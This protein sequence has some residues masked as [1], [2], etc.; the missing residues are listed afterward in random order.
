MIN[1]RLCSV[2]SSLLI[3]LYLFGFGVDA[4]GP[5]VD[6]WHSPMSLFSFGCVSDVPRGD[7]TGGCAAESRGATAGSPCTVRVAGLHARVE[8]R[9]GDVWKTRRTSHLRRRGTCSA[10]SLIRNS[11]KPSVVCK[12]TQLT[13][14]NR[15]LLKALSSDALKTQA[16]AQFEK[17]LKRAS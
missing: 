8:G 11:P 4:A 2:P 15:L 13:A 17:R 3:L 9:V 5:N 1:G 12:N 10:S 14:V 7:L 6:V 16:N